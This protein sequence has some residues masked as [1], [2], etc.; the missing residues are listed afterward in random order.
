MGRGGLGEGAARCC[1][2]VVGRGMC[3]MLRRVKGLDIFVVLGV[4]YLGLYVL[5]YRRFSE[6]QKE[7]HGGS[8]F[9]SGVWFCGDV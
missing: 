4:G 3:W 7:G 5:A 9:L 6:V 2:G 1:S 8:D